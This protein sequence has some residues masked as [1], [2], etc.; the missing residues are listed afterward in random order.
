MVFPERLFLLG[1]ISGITTS[2]IFLL[3]HQLV[4]QT[5]IWFVA[6][7]AIIFGILTGLTLTWS[8]QVYFSDFNWKNTLKLHG[9]YLLPIPILMLITLV[10]FEPK[11]TFEEANDPENT[12]ELLSTAF[13]IVIPYAFLYGLMQGFVY[14]RSIKSLKASISTH[15]VI[16]AGIGL[17]DRN[18]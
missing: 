11:W 17:N 5:P 18:K 15:L 2:L 7:M 12:D 16:L 9:I 6:P 3:L 1:V 10:F 13:L 14:K 4:L 8:Y